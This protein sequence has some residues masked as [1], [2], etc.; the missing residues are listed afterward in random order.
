MSKYIKLE[1]AIT[2][3]GRSGE[4]HADAIVDMLFFLPTIEVSEDAISDEIWK[5]IPDYEGY[6]E[7]SNLGRIHSVE[8]VVKSGRGHR[9][10]KS[11]LLKIFLDEWGYEKVSISK[12][13]KN[14]SRKVHTLVAKAF[15][16]NP[17]NYPQVNHIDG[18]KTHNFV[19][20][21]EWCNA[22]QNMN[23]CYGNGMS[24][25]QTKVKIVETGQVF[26]SLSECARAIGGDIRNIQMC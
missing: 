13:G 11:A 16:P 8:R 15:I 2:L 5:P 17:N 25:W 20:N 18:V 7:A 22:S 4:Y 19:N 23:H 14:V 12:D 21:L 3:F 26:N 6:Y 1:D 10:V 24:K 9:T